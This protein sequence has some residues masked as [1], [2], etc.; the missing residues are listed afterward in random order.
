MISFWPKRPA[1][2]A[3]LLCEHCERL[4]LNYGSFVI[5]RAEHNPTV[6]T[7][8][9]SRRGPSPGKKHMGTLRQILGRSVR[10]PLCRLI[11]RSLAEQRKTWLARI[12][13]NLG[14]GEAL[15]EV[16]TTVKD[17][18]V[19]CEASWQLDGREKVKND[20]GDLVEV[21]RTRRLCIQFPKSAY[22]EVHIVLVFP[23]VKFGPPPHFLGRF[24]TSLDGSKVDQIRRWYN[25]CLDA[26]GDNCF[27]DHENA[28][29]Q[30]LRKESYF[31]VL[32]L[33]EMQLSALPK[34]SSYA[35]LSYTW[36]KLQQGDNRFR[37]TLQNV[38]TLKLP[39]GVRDIEQQL[40]KTIRDTIALVRELGIRYLWVDSLCILQGDEELWALNASRMDSVY[41]NA[42]LTI[43]AA[44]GVDAHCGL[45]ALQPLS[46]K[47]DYHAKQ[48]IEKVRPDMQLMVAYPSETYVSRSVWNTRAWTFQER[49][50]SKRCLI[51][52]EG[53]VY[54]QCRSSTMSE[55]IHA[56]EAEAGWS[57]ELLYGPL[58]RY[59]NLGLHPVDV[60][61]YSVYLY[62]SRF[63]SQEED[64]L[65][66]FSGIGKEIC[67]RLGGEPIFALPNTHFDL[68][69]L[70]KPDNAP[71][72]RMRAGKLKFPSWAWCGWKGSRIT[73]DA[74]FVEGCEQNLH[75]WLM[76]HT[77]ITWY[78]RDGQGN[79]RLVWD[80]L[81]H[82]K[83]AGRVL[84][85]WQG[86]C[87]HGTEQDEA[88][89]GSR[90]LC[91]VVDRYQR[92]I[93]P[94]M[95]EL[96][97][98]KFYRTMPKYPYQVRMVEPGNRSTRPEERLEDQRFLQFWT[99]SAHFYL[100]PED[101][102]Q[103]FSKRS[104]ANGTDLIRFGVLDGDY[105]LVGTVTIGE[106]WGGRADLETR[107][108]FIAISDAKGFTEDEM[109][110]WN[111]VE[112][113]LPGQ[114]EWYAYNVLL[115]VYDDES[116][117]VAR[118]AALG[119]IYKR[120][121]DTACLMPDQKKKKEWKEIILG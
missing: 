83:N 76:N 11:V 86:Y 36:G 80:P 110:E 89:S 115:L 19:V 33:Q 104:K 120:A 23:D 44:D 77:W 87:G 100:V 22:T 56:E 37:T 73:Y 27:I 55:D 31:G 42:S 81:L 99:W 108:E 5:D 71:N 30:D 57:I 101:Q 85:R 88:S 21:P 28:Q 68:F 92:V 29:F 63:L 78:I 7:A 64:V 98:D 14:S 26:H 112:P 32:D 94:S 6:T 39:G 16:D 49:V 15:R 66:A 18:D 40:P 79:L 46:S 10:C 103:P 25:L 54:F 13:A 8:V 109:R 114:T 20:D 51:F 34:D 117:G 111:F 70:W 43:C 24:L 9:P 65:A 35:A 106:S 3:D 48:Y 93:A 41:G 38:D 107:H 72:R 67:H 91:S 119:K 97:R 12:V 116:R 4:N 17:L 90:D 69:L 58:Q 53:R 2:S 84:R 62:T 60:Y 75:E 59:K 102:E 96:R 118:R 50:L 52:A 82:C 61:K 105:N 95:R 113:S 45:T 1:D 74:S 47:Y 121:F